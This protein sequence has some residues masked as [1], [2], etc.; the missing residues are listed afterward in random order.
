[1]TGVQTC[2]LPIL[3]IEPDIVELV[4]RRVI[5]TTPNFSEAAAKEIEREI[6]D[7]F[8]GRR[9]FLPKGAKRLTHEEREALFKDGLT[10]MTTAEIT[11]KH[12]ISRS[13]MYRA[14]KQGG[15][16]G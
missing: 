3:D 1:M 12:K 11:E 2:A 5:A 4:L 16:F 10:N 6:K 13:T 8:G 14:M 7:Q 15:R 9:F